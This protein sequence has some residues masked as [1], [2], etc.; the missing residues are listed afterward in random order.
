MGLSLGGSSSNSQGTDSSQNTYTPGQSA[1][2][3]SLM[4]AFSKLLPGVASGSMSPNVTA[5]QTGNADQI[6]KSYDAVG[7][8][9][10]RFL[11][12]RGFGQSGETGK[13]QLQTELGRQGALG[14]NA[15]NAAGQQLNFDQSL[16]NDSLLA[17]FNKVGTTGSQAQSGSSSNWGASASAAFGF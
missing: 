2:Q 12:A 13:A 15:S 17:A 3:D 10:N 9:M 6:N 4:Q 8:R 16:L 11:A 14:A 1:L 7:T 5:M